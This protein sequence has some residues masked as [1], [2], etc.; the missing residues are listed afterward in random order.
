MSGYSSILPDTKGNSFSSGLAGLFRHILLLKSICLPI[1]Q[2]IL[3]RLHSVSSHR[4]L[5]ACYAIYGGYTSGQLPNLM[6][7]CALTFFF[8]N[9]GFNFFDSTLPSAFSNSAVASEQASPSKL[10]AS[11]LMGKSGSSTGTSISII[12]DFVLPIVFTTSGNGDVRSARSCRS[13]PSS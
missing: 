9:S 4:L 7:R 12:S 8:R 13:Y 1:R 11:M 6:L 3:V 10:S 5:L 2:G